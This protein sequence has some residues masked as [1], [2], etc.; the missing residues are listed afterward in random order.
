MNQPSAQVALDEAPQLLSDERD[1]LVA[2]AD[3]ARALAERIQDGKLGKRPA[4]REAASA[5]WTSIHVP[6]TLQGL[7]LDLRSLAAVH[8]E[9]G[10]F[11]G[12]T[13]IIA[14]GTLPAELLS[15]L[16]GSSSRQ[17]L[18]QGLLTGDLMVA[19]AWQDEVGQL[20]PGRVSAV[21]C[22]A[23]NGRLFLSGSKR[24]VV[25]AEGLDGWLVDALNGNGVRG[26]YWVPVDTPGVSVRTLQ[27]VDTYE[28]HDL[29]LDGV[30]VGEPLAEGDGVADAVGKALD[31]AR[32][33][34]AAELLGV[35]R[36][37]FEF[38]LDYLK[39][40]VQFGRPI[41]ANQVLQ[42]R[43]VDLYVRLEMA[44][45][46][47]K[48]AI[49]NALTRS[50][51]LEE[52]ASWT[53]SRSADVALL[54]TQSAVQLHGAI[55]ITDEY[56][57]GRYW[58][59]AIFLASWLGSPERNN[60]RHLELHESREQSVSAQ[61]AMDK[62]GGQQQGW[63]TANVQ[64]FRRM[65]RS[66]LEQNYPAELRNPPRRLRLHEVR[67][68]YQT[69]AKRGWLAPAWPKIHGGMGLSPDKLIA[70][71]EEFEEFGAA[72]M[73]DQGIINV[74]P[75]L[76]RYG[77]EEQRRRYLPKI[78]SGEEIW[79]QGYSEPGAGSDL[80]ALRTRA[81]RHGEHFIVNGQKIWTT[82]AQD[83]TH[84]FM[85]ARTSVEEKKQDGISFLLVALASPGVTVRP[86]RNI[87]GEEEFCEVFL[88]NVR[89]PAQDLVG[90]IGQG[91][92][93]GMA[94]LGYERLFVGSPKT[95][96]YALNQLKKLGRAKGLM[97]DSNF[98]ATY[99]RLLLE[100]LELKASF[101]GFAELASKGQELTSN[102]SILKIWATE[103]YT[104]IS[105]ELLRMAD[106]DG[107]RLG[108]VVLPD[109]EEVTPLTSLLN[110]SVT[111]IYGGSNEIQRN[112]VARRVLELPG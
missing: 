55:G 80:A 63:E 9:L 33:A 17:S 93:I 74:G 72:R 37:T 21:R 35:A 56:R 38:T 47:L 61:T 97:G 34:Q 46:G 20:G 57:L 96:Q 108:K 3:S 107:A 65:V 71:V 109:R 105:K 90:E 41:G 24:W 60:L 39:T 64:D 27:V 70:Y 4:W 83:A 68:W 102:V 75:I 84:M 49:S 54:L 103:L 59:R 98:R 69:L 50:I 100:L 1:V 51:G 26:L 16:P 95:S 91:W 44:A 87:G 28:V 76:I 22:S 73:P 62:T 8:E 89:V 79:C 77:T 32:V 58:K 25:G 12:E 29:V 53:K 67:T 66:F 43:M 42:H 45:A 86:I 52:A 7:G 99:G 36:A 78:L 85:L 2:F 5:G 82:L 11:P 106:E 23:S 104:R 48:A 31:V 13:P 111:T 88:D 30:I 14:C 19:V 101:A 10:R 40:R 92:K 110:A 94:L 6:E 112:I 81:D 18:L 15:R